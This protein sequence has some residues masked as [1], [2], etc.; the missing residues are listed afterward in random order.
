MA[1]NAS[2]ISQNKPLL[3]EFPKNTKEDWRNATDKLLKGKPFEK[4]MLTRTYEDIQLQ[5]IYDKEDFDTLLLTDNLPGFPF[6]L[7]NTKTLGYLEQEWKI[8]QEISYATAERFRDALLHDLDCGQTGVNIKLDKASLEGRDP[9]QAEKEKVGSQGTSLFSLAELEI[10][11]DKVV[12]DCI[13]ID[14]YAPITAPYMLSMLVA[15]AKKKDAIAR[16]SRDVSEWI[17]SG[18]YQKM[19]KYMILSRYMMKWPKR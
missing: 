18:F 17:L 9:D 13:D 14:I 15:L 7:R 11:L 19:E 10:A 16:N 12:L 1:D 2:S 6:Y 8:S 3:T 5:P 4:I